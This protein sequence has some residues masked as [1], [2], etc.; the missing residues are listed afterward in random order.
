MGQPAAPEEAGGGWAQSA[1]RLVFVSIPYVITGTFMLVAVAINFAN[2]LARYLFGEAIFWTEEVL[3]FLMIYSVFLA[4]VSIAFN[5]DNINMD[6][7]YARFSKPVRRA[8]NAAIL[9]VFVLACTFMATQSYKVFSLHLRNG[10][11][12]VA[13]GIP[14]AVPHSALLIGFALMALALCWRW[15]MYIERDPPAERQ[16]DILE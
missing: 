3:G 16:A 11:K 14:M 10:T 8:V 15:R 4:A 2:I 9:I 13:A 1:A 5:A 6:L 7:F 12:S